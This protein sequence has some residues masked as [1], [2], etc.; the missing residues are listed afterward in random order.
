MDS[1]FT[2]LSSY[3]KLKK[4]LKLVIVVKKYI[5][6]FDFGVIL[7]WLF[8]LYNLLLTNI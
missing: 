7:N 8:P 4:F 1:I 2:T 3:L 6:N 5:C